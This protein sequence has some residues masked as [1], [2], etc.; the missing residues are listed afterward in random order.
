MPYQI[1]VPDAASLITD[2]ADTTAGFIK[3]A[4]ER[5]RRATP[6]VQEARALQAAAAA[7]PTVRQLLAEPALQSALLTAAGV[8]DKDNKYFTAADRQRA[9]TEFVDSYLAPTRDYPE[10]LALRF[11]LT[12]GDQLG[13]VMRNVVGVLGE[14]QLLRALLAALRLRQASV[15]RLTNKAG[16]WEPITTV[17]SEPERGT[18]ALAWEVGGHARVL[19]LNQTVP[20]VNK[21]ID[22]V[23][24]AAD[25]REVL[26]PADRKAVLAE[27]T[28]YV[29]FGELK[30]GVD[31][32]GS[33]EHW[34]TAQTAFDRIRA[35]FADA[36][37]FFV[38]GAIV[39][40]MAQE[41]WTDLQA[42]KIRHA[43]NLTHDTQV[44]ALADWLVSV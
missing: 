23:L 11:L 20:A 16:P 38:G 2:Q 14:E 4:L 3:M 32:S 25:V 28:R 36:P 27:P 40:S 18:R 39:S 35:V 8:S 41:I 30:G 26:A 13:G 17:I 44:A 7:L 31:P 19:L 5:S 33:D 10:E 34:K 12:R 6:H 29:A 22:L 43:A 1:S 21:N 24:L 42:G 37:V 15:Q 9:V